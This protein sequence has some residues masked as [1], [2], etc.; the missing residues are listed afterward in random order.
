M[1]SPCAEGA[2][3][4]RDVCRPRRSEG[5]AC[6]QDVECG[7]GLFCH[8]ERRVCEAQ[9][10]VTSPAPMIATSSTAPRP[11]SAQIVSAPSRSTDARA[12]PARAQGSVCEAV[13]GVTARSVVHFEVGADC[14]EDCSCGPLGACVN[15][16]CVD[17]ANSTQ[18]ALETAT[19]CKVWRVGGALSPPRGELSAS[20]I[21]REDRAQV[22]EEARLTFNATVSR[23]SS[24][25]TVGH[26]MVDR[27]QGSLRSRPRASW[28]RRASTR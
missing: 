13:T 1:S 16:Q 10:G 24:R 7:P 11:C 18:S 3:C 15:L 14:A 21:R 6:E 8:L 2:V 25:S 9:R 5:Q 22:L 27:D 23:P 4:V 20:R 19:A 28:S 26:A 12:A 17:Q